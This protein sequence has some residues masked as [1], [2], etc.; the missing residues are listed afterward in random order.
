MKVHFLL[1]LSHKLL[2][3]I[4][5]F[6]ACDLRNK[7]DHHAF[8]LNVPWIMISK[9]LN[10]KR[11][12]E[13][14]PKH[15]PGLSTINWRLKMKILPII[16]DFKS[17]SNKQ[18]C[19]TRKAPEIENFMVFNKDLLL[20]KKGLTIFLLLF[21]TA[22]AKKPKKSRNL[23]QHLLAVRKMKHISINFPRQ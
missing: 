11:E 20:E 9:T 7:N 21:S 13:F 3:F 16:P 15:F 22:G 14:I 6:F 10:Y 8:G 23:D 4:D 17:P 19:S 5:W 2:R 18:V 1:P 12:N